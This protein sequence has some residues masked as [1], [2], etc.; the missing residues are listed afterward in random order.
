M[1]IKKIDVHFWNWLTIYKEYSK[2]LDSNFNQGIL[3]KVS[4]NKIKYYKEYLSLS[5]SY[6]VILTS[7]KI[8]ELSSP[9]ELLSFGRCK[10]IDKKVLFPY[11]RCAIIF[12]RYKE[13][14]SNPPKNQ[15]P[16]TSCMDHMNLKNSIYFE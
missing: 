11:E 5:R 9:H 3:V 7:C 13:D 15:N 6:K 8:I 16:Y 4:K 14:V 2:Y 1:T 12:G 10:M